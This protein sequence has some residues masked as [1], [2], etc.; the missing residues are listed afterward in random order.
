LKRKIR[1]MKE[2][3]SDTKQHR[4]APRNSE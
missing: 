1:E 2:K 4:R 3:R